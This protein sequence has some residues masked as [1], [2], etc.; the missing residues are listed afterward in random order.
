ML[1][2]ELNTIA[3]NGYNISTGGNTNIMYGEDHPRNT[4]SNE[5]VLN[6]IQELKDNKLS[7]RAIAKKYGCTDKIVADINHGYSHNQDNE[8]YPIRNK[9]G[10]QKINKEQLQEII[11]K[12]MNTNITYQEIANEYELSK[13]AIYHINKGLTFHNDNYIYPLRKINKTSEEITN[14]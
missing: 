13:G 10:L 2:S 11:D 6:I 3:P 14:G 4:V 1:I 5:D 8:I 9:K 12:L 7:D